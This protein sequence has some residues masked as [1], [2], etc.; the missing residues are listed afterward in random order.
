MPEGDN[1]LLN[2]TI[3]EFNLYGNSQSLALPGT[4]IAAI[5]NELG[6]SKA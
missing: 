4:A 1:C 5:D 2:F 6:T 3:Q